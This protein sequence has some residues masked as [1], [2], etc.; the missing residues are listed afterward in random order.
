MSTPYQTP[1]SN[2][3]HSGMISCKAC[4]KEIH[5]SV[6]ICPH[7]GA[8]QRKS[9][10]KSKYVAAILAFFLG[11]LGI[12]RFYLGQWWGIFYLLFFWLWIPGLVALIEF[13]YFLV[14]DTSKWDD[15]YNEGIPRGPNESS[16]GAIIALVAIAGVFVFI[17]FVG[18]L[19]AIAI[20][21]Y[22]DYM[23]RAKVA[24]ALTA[25]RPVQSEMV[26]YYN[27]KGELPVSNSSLGLEEP[28]IIA[29]S[30][31]ATLTDN[32]ITILFRSETSPL[33]SKNIVLTPIMKDGGIEWDCRGGDIEN[34]YRPASC[35]K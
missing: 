1:N 23:T 17:M 7:C 24:E 19:A 11:G 14:C 27:E 6:A 34:K 13:I 12:H 10:Y 35:R 2:L 29:G 33:N 15:R 26:V 16:G 31:E 9:R 25:T 30:H 4:N 32:G 18:I 5:S 21:A 28:Y 3:Q 22:Q 8:S 20:P